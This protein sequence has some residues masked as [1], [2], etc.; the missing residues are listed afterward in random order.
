MSESWIRGRTVMI[1]GAT[2][3]IG[4]STAEALARLG[5]EI[6]LVCRDLERGDR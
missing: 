3:G 2:S 6:V 4:R 5:A 1:T